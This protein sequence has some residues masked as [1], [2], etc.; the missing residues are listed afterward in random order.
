MLESAF[1]AARAHVPDIV[2]ANVVRLLAKERAL[3]FFSHFV[4]LKL[5]VFFHKCSGNLCFFD[6]VYHFLV[7]ESIVN[8]ELLKKLSGKNLFIEP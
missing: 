1:I 3:P 8:T 7:E 4:F 6:R 2:A 5:Y